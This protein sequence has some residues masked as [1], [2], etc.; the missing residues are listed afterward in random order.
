MLLSTEVVMS[1]MYRFRSNARRLLPSLVVLAVA[2]L[3][4]APLS[5]AQNPAPAQP[6]QQPDQTAPDANG[7][8]PDN[9]TIAIPKKKDQPEEAPPRALPGRPP[10]GRDRNRCPRTA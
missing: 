9:G 6:Q 1:T 10:C 3:S 8:A 5:R 2:A 7:P 4:A